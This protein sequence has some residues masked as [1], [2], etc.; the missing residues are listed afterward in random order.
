[1]LVKAAA[2]G[3]LVGLLSRLDPAMPLNVLP[4]FGLLVA[5]ELLLLL[6]NLRREAEQD[7]PKAKSPGV[8]LRPAP[9]RSSA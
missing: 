8:R 4:S 9:T 2:L 7:A 1:M 5:A 3:F 6:W